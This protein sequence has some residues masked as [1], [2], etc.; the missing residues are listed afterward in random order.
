MYCSTLA[1]G[2]RKNETGVEERIG[3]VI[4]RDEMIFEGSNGELVSDF[5]SAKSN[6][7][8]E[9]I[10]MT[11]GVWKKPGTQLFIAN[12]HFLSN[13][14][15]AEHLRRELFAF[16]SKCANQHLSDLLSNKTDDPQQVYRNLPL[17][18]DSI[19]PS[20]IIRAIT[21][22]LASSEEIPPPLLDF[23][24]GTIADFGVELLLPENHRV[25][26]NDIS[27]PLTTFDTFFQDIIAPFNA[28]TPMPSQLLVIVD[29]L[30]ARAE[31]HE[32]QASHLFYNGGAAY[33][34][35]IMIMKV[36]S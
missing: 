2:T 12:S 22:L 8:S 10:P 28:H 17:L 1:T 25:Y 23:L 27:T 3:F 11:S 30:L 35:S 26:G 18:S 36:I 34:R 4:A 31:D 20:N 9:R 33:W 13:N 24:L 14:L 5:D 16:Q 21:Q 15:L 7:G 6:T 32:V 29:K 19:Y